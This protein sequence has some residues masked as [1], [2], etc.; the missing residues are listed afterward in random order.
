MRGCGC[1]VR[2]QDMLLRLFFVRTKVLRNSMPPD[3]GGGLRGCGCEVRE[4]DMLLRL[5]FVRIRV[6]RKRKR[7]MMFDILG[8]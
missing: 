7:N 4:P 6:L 5:F 3:L 1:G 2:E 8:W